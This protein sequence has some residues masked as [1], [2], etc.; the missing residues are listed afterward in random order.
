PLMRVR[1]VALRGWARVLKRGMDLAVGWAILVFLSPVMLVTAFIIKLTSPEGPVLF[2][3]ER[4]GLDGRPFHM[5]KFRSMR[6][7]AEADTGPV[8]A[9]PDDNRRTPLGT[10]MRRFSIDEWPQFVNVLMGEMS[11]VGPR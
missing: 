5:I 8:W 10:F 9:R 3:Q 7:D 4:V 11:L 2:V 1:D 6:P